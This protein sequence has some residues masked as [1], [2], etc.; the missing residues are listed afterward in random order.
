MIFNHQSSNYSAFKKQIKN[1]VS[2]RG[3]AQQPKAI[4][5]GIASIIPSS[6]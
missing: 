2:L 4:H 6:K 5:S 1:C 3:V